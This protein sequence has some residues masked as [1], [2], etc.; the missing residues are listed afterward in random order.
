M[1]PM[2]TEMLT[3]VDMTEEERRA[4]IQELRDKIQRAEMRLAR[5]GDEWLKRVQ[6]EDINALYREL[7]KLEPET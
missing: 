3:A 4:A 6:R 5:T 2:E 7:R 1:S